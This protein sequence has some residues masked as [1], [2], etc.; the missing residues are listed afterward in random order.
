MTTEITK[1]SLADLA[2]RINEAHRQCEESA[3]SAVQHAVSAGELLNEAKTQCP[4]GEWQKWVADHCTFSERTAQLYQRVARELPKLAEAKAQRV[5]DLS[6]RET[7]KLLAGPIPATMQEDD[8]FELAFEV[9]NGLDIEDDED[10]FKHAA[11]L[12][13]EYLK[14]VAW[15]LTSRPDSGRY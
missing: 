8:L 13:E 9:V 15:Y 1:T 2:E 10:R 5:A 11:T 14:R 12:T 7:V 6:L 4:H 3:R